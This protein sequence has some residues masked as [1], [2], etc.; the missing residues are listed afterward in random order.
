MEMDAA[1][2]TYFLSVP[3]GIDSI[4]R[5]RLNELR[6]K[7]KDNAAMQ[8]TFKILKFQLIFAALRRFIEKGI[9]GETITHR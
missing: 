2:C 9:K 3:G 6:N 1:T 4:T 7:H 8:E 5:L